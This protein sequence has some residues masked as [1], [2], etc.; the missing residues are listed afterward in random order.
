MVNLH[1]SSGCGF[2][3]DRVPGGYF[4]RLHGFDQE[5]WDLQKRK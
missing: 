2:P 3:A 1:S 5:K 4:K